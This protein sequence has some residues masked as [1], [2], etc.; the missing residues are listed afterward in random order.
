MLRLFRSDFCGIYQVTIIR[1]QEFIAGCCLNVYVL[2]FGLS[3][4]VRVLMK[5]MGFKPQKTMKYVVFQIKLF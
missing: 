3:V 5:K 4:T 1:P 2:N